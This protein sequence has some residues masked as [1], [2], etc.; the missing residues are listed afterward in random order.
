MA[1]HLRTTGV[2]ITL[3]LRYHNSHK[4]IGEMVDGEKINVVCDAYVRVTPEWNSRS[5]NDA[6]SFSGAQRETRNRFMYGV[7]I[8]VSNS[9]RFEYFEWKEFFNSIMNSV[10]VF[11]LP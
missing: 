2:Y 4:Y 5:Y 9:A 7:T 10:V 8:E 3:E 1:P 11:A 6:A